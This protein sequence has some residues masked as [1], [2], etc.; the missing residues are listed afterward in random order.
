M[1]GLK[2]KP[3]G[4]AKPFWDPR[5]TDTPNR[6][7]FLVPLN[8]LAW[9]GAILGLVQ[10]SFNKLKSLML[11]GAGGGFAEGRE[12]KS[13]TEQ[14]GR[15]RAST[16]RGNSMKFHFEVPQGPEIEKKTYLDPQLPLFPATFAKLWATSGKSGW[17]FS[18]TW[19]SRCPF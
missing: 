13:G 2:G 11:Y 19:G 16:C 7:V 3:T 15:N 18:S 12:P 1:G 6:G 5:K 14:G 8:P 10:G 4:T 17:H 9:L